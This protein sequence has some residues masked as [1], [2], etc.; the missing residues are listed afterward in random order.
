METKT[1][2]AMVVWSVSLTVEVPKNAT[3]EEK[4]D[5]IMTAAMDAEIDFKHPIIH[6]CSDPECID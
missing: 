3:T 5:A 2:T 6:E 1:I 4:K